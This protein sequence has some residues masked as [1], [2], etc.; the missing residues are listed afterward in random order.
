MMDIGK[1][2]RHVWFALLMTGGSILF[3]ACVGADQD[4]A[5]NWVGSVTTPSGALVAVKLTIGE[6]TPGAK[7]THLHFGESR[8][9]DL[10]AEFSGQAGSKAL[11]AFTNSDGGTYCDRY[12]PGTLAV[13]MVGDDQVH[14]EMQ[15]QDKSHVDAGD[16]KRAGK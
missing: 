4:L 9:C 1:Q 7:G 3:A 13:N 5:G 2:V 14:F 16:L 8:S 15:S 11:F 10:D 6:M 12:F